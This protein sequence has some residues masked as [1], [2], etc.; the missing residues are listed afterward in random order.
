MNNISNN[1]CKVD[2]SLFFVDAFTDEAFKGNPAAVCLL[3]EDISDDLKQKIA[4][5]IGF[6]ETCFAI[7][8]KTKPENFNLRWFTPETEVPLCGHGTLSTAFVIW[9]QNPNLKKTLS[10]KTK[11]GLLTVVKDN[12][13][14]VMDFPIHPV[15]Q[16]N[17]IYH[18]LEEAI[19]LPGT[20]RR[21]FQ[22]KESGYLLLEIEPKE[23]TNLDIDFTKMKRANISPFNSFIVTSKG[24][25]EYDFFSR[26]FAVWEGINED[27][28]TGSAH[29][30]LVDYWHKKNPDQLSYKA[31]QCSPRGGRLVLELK[32]N[33]VLIRGKAIMI[34]KGS[35]CSLI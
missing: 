31:F 24:D 32:N 13:E 10:F 11:S 5:E 30:V 20:G 22:S 25:D 35:L 1:N 33:R 34:M 3:E 27:P 18:S 29:T 21:F 26:C 19:G 2:Y 17:I 14:I 28:V 6:S 23:I 16:S 9:N 8:D 7:Q 4:F 15:E 12:D